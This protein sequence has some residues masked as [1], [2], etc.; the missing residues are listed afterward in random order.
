MTS[1]GKIDQSKRTSR[2]ADALAVR[3]QLQAACDLYESAI[4]LDSN[5]AQLYFRL[6]VCQWRLGLVQAEAS[7]RRAIERN[8]QFTMA[9]AALSAWYLQHGLVEQA[10]SASKRAMELSPLD[11]GAM[12]SR[13]SVLE[14]V[15]DLDAA[16]DLVQQ[17]V[18]RRFTPLPVI[19]LYGRMA[20]YHRRQNQALDLV[21]KQ[22]AGSTQSSMDR[23]RLHFTAAELLDSL[24]RFD[25][26]FNHARQGNLLAKSPYD[27]ALHQR[28]FDTLIQYFT[29]E[30]LA[31]LPKASDRSEKPVFIVGMPRSGSS[32][33]EQILAS[34]PAIHGAGELDFMAHVW[35]GA[36]GMLSTAKEQYPACLDHLNQ[37][38][39]DGIAQIYL[40]P[41]VALD[42]SALRITDKL[43]LNFLNLGLISL[44]LPGAR[45]IDVR[46]DPRDTCLSCF[47][48]MFEGGNDFKFDLNHTAHF[49]RQYRRLMEH[50]KSS[51]DLPILDVSYEELVTDPE[52]QVRRMLEFL[53][54]PWDER[55]LDFHKS[56]RSVITSSMQ[57]VR[58]PLYQSSIGRW[59]N[60]QQ[61][62]AD[63]S[64]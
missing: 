52:Q 16:W 25:E 64:F 54:V 23:A 19:R 34:H 10:D 49:Y 37:D 53:G 47:M 17:L 32:L 44:L 51:L 55:C 21:E 13:A 15:G 58:R 12:Q 42:P 45:V 57:Q 41:L 22:S 28:T 14:A 35:S 18:D 60:Y 62:L 61:Y 1:A 40:Q 39:V 11:G 33:V 56:K 36:V 31:A 20:R 30:K 26:A 48:A 2:Q 24:G 27:P 43:P 8:P 4:D 6:A 38:Q 5:D 7:L 63:L 29:K 50:W 46:R 9:N 3:G 59:C